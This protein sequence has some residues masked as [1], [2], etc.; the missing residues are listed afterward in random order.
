MLE[1]AKMAMSRR[2]LDLVAGA[3][4]LTLSMATKIFHVPNEVQ[5]AGAG[6]TGLATLSSTEASFQEGN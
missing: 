6:E 4:G 2:I 3:G 5:R 1:V